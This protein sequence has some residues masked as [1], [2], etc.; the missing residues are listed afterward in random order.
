M[1][2]QGVS[3]DDSEAAKWY[4]KAAEGNDPRAQHSLGRMY[5]EGR[6]VVRDLGEA[7]RWFREAV[8]QDH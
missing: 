1:R 5:R 3:R 4:R 8:E 2:A 6:G 7:V